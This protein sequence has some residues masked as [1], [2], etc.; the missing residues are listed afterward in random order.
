MDYVILFTAKPGD[1][2]ENGIDLLPERQLCYGNNYFEG[3]ELVPDS[4]SSSDESE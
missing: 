3:L 2:Q 1:F 4:A